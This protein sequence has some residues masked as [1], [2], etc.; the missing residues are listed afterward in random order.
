[1]RAYTP[2]RRTRRC[3]RRPPPEMAN[4]PTTTSLQG[5]AR[6]CKG[7]IL[8]RCPSILSRSSPRGWPR[9]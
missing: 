9:W 1:M 6:P 5:L 7:G 8:K 4:S 3:C 2:L